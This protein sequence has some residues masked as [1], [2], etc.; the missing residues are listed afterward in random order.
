MF[1]VDFSWDMNRL[2]VLINLCILEG[3]GVFMVVRLFGLWVVMIL[4]SL[5]SGCR[6]MVIVMLMISVVF[7]IISDNCSVDCIRIVWVSFC[8]VFVVFVIVIMNGILLM[9]VEVV[10]VRLVICMGLFWNVLLV[11]IG[12]LLG[13]VC[14]MGR[15]V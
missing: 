1:S 8:C 9:L 7:S 6:L 4:F 5:C 15:F 2:I 10:C 3:M 13:C 14:V 11:K 12:L